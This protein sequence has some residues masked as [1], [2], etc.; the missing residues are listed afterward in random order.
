MD[1]LCVSIFSMKSLNGEM[2]LKIDIISNMLLKMLLLI[3][4]GYV[5]EVSLI[6]PKELHNYH[7]DL[8]LTPKN[9]ILDNSKQD[10]LLKILN[11]K[12]NMLYIIEL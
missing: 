9:R 3:Q 5:L 12:K 8:P 7:S 1:G 2:K 10:V 6:Y 11:D 4:T